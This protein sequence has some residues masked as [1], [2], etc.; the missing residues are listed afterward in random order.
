MKSA[1]RP[2]RAL[3]KT[4]SPSVEPWVTPGP[5]KSEARPMA[6]R[7]RPASGG[8]QQLG[9]HGRPGPALDA[10]G[11]Q[12]QV[13]GHGAAADRAVAVQVLQAH[14]Q[15]AGAF[16]G[17]QHAPLQRREP[18]RPL[19]VGGVQ[20]LVDDRR[21]LGRVGGGFGVGG[22]GGPPVHAGQRGRPVPGHRPDGD[23]LPGQVR[24]Q[25]TA[26]LAGPEHDVE[27]ILT[28]ARLLAGL[29]LL[30]HRGVP[31]LYAGLFGQLGSVGRG[32]IRHGPSGSVIVMV[33]EPSGHGWRW[34]ACRIQPP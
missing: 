23:T 30:R 25:G 4:R 24:G 11:G 31:F 26:D 2:A 19:V 17:G 5:K 33:P 18:F 29:R 27:S 20:A 22:I 1:R 10:G 8:G 6:M 34:P 13:L 14:Q 3:P 28:H 16:G 32:M 21:A 12:R 15:R 7:T 9:G